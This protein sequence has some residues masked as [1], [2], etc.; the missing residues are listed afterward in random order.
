MDPDSPGA[1]TQ[2]QLWLEHVSVA[3]SLAQNGMVYQTNNV[4]YVIDQNNLW[5]T[6]STSN[7][8]HMASMLNSGVCCFG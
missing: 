5:P 4:Q 2:R 8:R 6:R 3:D 1:V 7:T